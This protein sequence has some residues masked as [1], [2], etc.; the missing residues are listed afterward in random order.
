MAAAGET[1]QLKGQYDSS[2]RETTGTP[3]AGLI[4]RVPSAVGFGDAKD[5][6]ADMARLG[7][8]QEFEASTIL[9]L[10]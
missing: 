3:K 10:D 4:G 7:K 6:L 2:S 8:K 5:D 1:Y 9:L